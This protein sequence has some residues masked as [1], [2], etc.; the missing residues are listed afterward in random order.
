MADASPAGTEPPLQGP[1]QSEAGTDLGAAGGE[2][3]GGAKKRKA[4]QRNEAK[5]LLK[6]LVVANAQSVVSDVSMTL[7]FTME[8]RT[9]A[10]HLPLTT[11]PPA[12]F[13]DTHELL[14]AHPRYAQYAELLKAVVRRVASRASVEPR[15]C[16][17]RRAAMMTRLRGMGPFPNSA[18]A[19]VRD[20]RRRD[21]SRA[22]RARAA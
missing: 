21:Q 2:A 5:A 11:L 15:P 17:R 3:V 19:V 10:C 1:A 14:E 4:P 13:P 12:A 22:T 8:G 20:V 9:Y 6:S 18:P 7:S 16:A